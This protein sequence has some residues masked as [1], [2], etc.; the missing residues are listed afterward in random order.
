MIIQKMKAKF[1]KLSGDSLAFSPG[2]NIIMA[3]NESGKSTWATFLRTM[4][5]GMQMDTQDK[6]GYTPWDGQDME[7][8]MVVRLS[9]QIVSLQRFREQ[10]TQFGGFSAVNETVGGPIPNL[11]GDNCGEFLV[12]ASEAVFLRTA[13]LGQG[14]SSTLSA[15]PELEKKMATLVTTGQD[16]ISYSNAVEQINRW[17]S[18]RKSGEEGTVPLLEQE[19]EKLVDLERNILARHKELFELAY[20][21]QIEKNKIT[22]IEEKLK[23]F[24]QEEMR[25]LGMKFQK[26]KD[27]LELSQRSRLNLLQRRQK[28]GE[29]PQ[30][31]Q[32]V[33]LKKE[34]ENVQ[35]L[36]PQIKEVEVGIRVMEDE[37]EEAEEKAKNSPLVGLSSEEALEKMGID[38]LT[39]NEVTA[40][41]NKWKNSWWGGLTIALAAGVMVAMGGY[42]VPQYANL[43]GL[44][45]GAT[46]IIVGGMILLG[47]YSSYMSKRKEVERILIEYQVEE[48]QDMEIFGQKYKRYLELSASLSRKIYTAHAD[49]AVARREQ[50]DRHQEVLSDVKRFSPHVSTLKDAIYAVNQAM[51]LDDQLEIV[52]QEVTKAKDWYNHLKELGGDDSIPLEEVALPEESKDLLLRNRAVLEEKVNNLVEKKERAQEELGKLSTLAEVTC[53]KELTAKQ[54]AKAQQEHR[55]IAIAREGVARAHEKVR[56]RFYP[57]LNNIAGEYFSKL[58]AGKY[59]ALALTREFSAY[60]TRS[61]SS[62]ARNAATLSQ[63]TVDQIYLAVRLAVADLCLTNGVETA[64]IILDDALVSMDQGRMEQALDLLV[65]LGQ[66]RQIL[67][68]T[69]HGR[70]GKYLVNQPTT[71]II[72]I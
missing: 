4:L 47:G 54:L 68:F 37:Q 36:A 49:L 10:N 72:T 52:E 28:F 3:P 69:C 5:Y 64:P 24:H 15:V 63:G 9:N 19:L 34:L 39:V 8:E 7:G 42:A 65:E 43:F 53:H 38:I 70:E 67:L 32:L 14:G 13:F 20:K 58:T 46:F 26:G 45:G 62:E 16:D 59:K 17:L 23:L 21:V 57:E 11:T 27:S 33:L 35:A 6:L 12:G 2:L 31:D 48:W 66:R 71:K 50:A 44:A 1:G 18:D 30:K 56:Q 25:E 22:E 51:D 60:A 61:G 40:K 55:A 41:M 29:L